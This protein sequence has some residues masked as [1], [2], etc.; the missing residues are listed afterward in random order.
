MIALIIILVLAL[1]T[2]FLS[3]VT[4]QQ[5]TIAIITMF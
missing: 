3:I 5:G 4:V 2:V 1:V